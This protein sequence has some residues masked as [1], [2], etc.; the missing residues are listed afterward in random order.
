MILK[1]PH[2]LLDSNWAILADFS[3]GKHQLLS[4]HIRWL[5][6]MAGPAL[7]AGNWVCIRG[8][9]SKLGSVQSNQILSEQRANEVAR[10]LRSFPSARAD[11][12]TM[13]RGSGETFS[14]GGPQDD[15]SAWR[16]VE[17]IITPNRQ[18]TLPRIISIPLTQI[19][20]Q[21][22]SRFS[23]SVL[24]SHSIGPFT[25]IYFLVR[26]SRHG[27]EARFKA[28]MA[29]VSLAPLNFGSS[30]RASEI[31]DD[32]QISHLSDFHRARVEMISVDLQQRAPGRLGGRQTGLS[33]CR[34]EIR[35]F[36]FL[37]N[38]IRISRFDGGSSMLPDAGGSIGDL[39]N[40]PR[41]EFD[42][43]TF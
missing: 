3:T 25:T 33:F 24:D 30:G 1:H 40:Q 27:K 12:I 42:I 4:D 17:V 31:P 37:A 28:V 29:G 9:A 21:R 20:G 41:G 22:P 18:S 14:S 8:L 43:G 7:V 36:N 19:E 26:D 10:H 34:L 5:D 35:P 13:V 11:H 32:P 23:I 6:T 38:R 39:M 2:R 15:S 16:S